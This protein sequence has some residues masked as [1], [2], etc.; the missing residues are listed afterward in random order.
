M[1]FDVKRLAAVVVLVVV[2]LG[3]VIVLFDGLGCG[4]TIGIRL[5]DGDKVLLQGQI[6]ILR[7]TPPPPENDLGIKIQPS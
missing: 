2:I 3:G 7:V 4:A 5:P 6:Q 1:K